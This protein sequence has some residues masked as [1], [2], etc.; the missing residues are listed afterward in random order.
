MAL[1]TG[2]ITMN[3]VNIE[4][5]RSSGGTISLNDSDVR[6]LAGRPSGTISMDDLRGKSAGPSGTWYVDFWPQSNNRT[7]FELF[8]TGVPASAYWEILQFPWFNTAGLY[9]PG[10]NGG[11]NCGVVCGNADS[12]GTIF[13]TASNNNDSFWWPAQRG[14]F[15]EIRIHN[16]TSYFTTLFYV[17]PSIS[18]FNSSNTAFNGGTWFTF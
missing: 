16:G 6:N 11:L 1:P 2:T 15:T 5:G 8:V 18:V 10:W 17:S 7:F 13:W 3:D 12:G 14:N 9:P 4:L